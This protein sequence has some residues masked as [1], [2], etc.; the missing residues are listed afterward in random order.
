MLI[1]KMHAHHFESLKDKG[2]TNHMHRFFGR[3]RRERDLPGSS[4][5]PGLLADRGAEEF[6]VARAISP[7]RIVREPV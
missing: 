5:I 3:R 7:H 2:V 1:A 6:I 4:E